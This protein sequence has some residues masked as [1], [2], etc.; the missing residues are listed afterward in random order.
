M[1]SGLVQMNLKGNDLH[2]NV[3][4]L[5]DI[6]ETPYFQ[7]LNVTL[8]C[9]SVFCILQFKLI[10]WL[11]PA[12]WNVIDDRCSI[13]ETLYRNIIEETSSYSI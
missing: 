3:Q 7:H 1:L 11:A 6:Y 10:T 2:S 9:V 5:V 12:V 13:A 4:T 8:N